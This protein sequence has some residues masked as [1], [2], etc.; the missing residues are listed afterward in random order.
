M[1]E[2]ETSWISHSRWSVRTITIYN[3]E[4]DLLTYQLVGTNYLWDTERFDAGSWA[5]G[6]Y[7]RKRWDTELDL[8]TYQLVG[9]NYLFLCN[10][11]FVQNAPEASTK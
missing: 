5:T 3:T 8:L 2:V 9:T 6:W 11:E 10:F 4:L 7:S 1:E